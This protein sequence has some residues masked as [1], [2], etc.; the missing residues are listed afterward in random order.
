M[1]FNI[2]V[3]NELRGF[4][5]YTQVVGFMYDYIGT[6]ITWVSLASEGVS[7]DSVEWEL[8]ERWNA[9]LVKYWNGW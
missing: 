4:L 3:P 1:V 2:S 7:I 9:G 5:F 8:V 6:D